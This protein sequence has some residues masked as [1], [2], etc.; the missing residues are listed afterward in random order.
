VLNHPLCINGKVP[1][2]KERKKRANND[3]LMTC[4]YKL[5]NAG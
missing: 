4:L 2:E 1:Y 3:V 5:S